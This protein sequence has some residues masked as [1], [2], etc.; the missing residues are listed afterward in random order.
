MP[1]F[2]VARNPDPNSTLPYVIRIPVGEKGLVLKTGETWPR[3][4]KVY[5]HRS[6][7]GWPSTPEIIESVEVKMCKRRGVAIDLVLARGRENRSQFV[8]TRLKG[9]REAIFWQTARTARVSRPAVRVPG[10]RASWLTQFVITVD[11]RER[12]PYRFH[13]QQVATERASLPFGDYGVLHDDEVVA[14]VERKSLQD[15]S[16]ALS[17]GS[18][19]FLMAA[20]SSYP[21]AAVVVEDRYS[22]LFKN[23]YM[24]GGLLADL[25]ARVQVRYPSVP[26]VFCDTRP[27]AEEW[28]FRFLGAA[29]AVEVDDP[30]DPTSPR[31][32]ID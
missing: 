29:L 15:L 28:T 24:S 12:Y 23:Q 13:K 17:D 19:A 6:E 1:A 5:C 8:F 32:W 21:R 30:E 4:S 3:L 31:A 2:L 14:L 20:L 11:T 10:R 26:I 9:G 22:S 25:V 27:L 7:E 18:L 16:K